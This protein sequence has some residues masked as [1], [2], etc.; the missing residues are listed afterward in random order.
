VKSEA[1]L[2]SLTLED[3]LPIRSLV[4]DPDTGLPKHDAEGNPKVVDYFRKKDGQPAEIALKLL[5]NLE[6]AKTR[7]VWR[8][9]VALSIRHVG[10]VAARALADK[11]GSTRAIFE[12]TEEELSA[13]DGVGPGLAASI[14]SWYQESWHR[15]ILERWQEAG[16]VL[17][18]PG[19]QPPDQSQ[20]TGVFAGMSI[21]VTGS[22]ESMTRD[23]I[24]ELIIENGGKPA[25]SVSKKTSLLVA[26]PG[27]GSKLEKATALS[28][29]VLSEQQFFEKLA[30]SQN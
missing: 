23:Q 22:M 4:L 30:A 1:D 17:E 9:L 14:I 27:A 7:P 20:P 11:F 28:V 2:F 18:I 3:L 24:E 8:L 6:K 12:A 16:V 15:E 29:E 13:V 10:P 26:G 5:A 21:V 25:S 19:H